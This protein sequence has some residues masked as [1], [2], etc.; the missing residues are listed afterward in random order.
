MYKKSS[1]DK[2]YGKKKFF[3]GKE[4]ID[5]LHFLCICGLGGVC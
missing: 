1:F 3:F 5:D 2:I 4:E